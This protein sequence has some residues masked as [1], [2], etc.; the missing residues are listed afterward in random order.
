MK[1]PTVSELATELRAINRNVECDPGG[2]WAN[3]TGCDVRLQVYPDGQWAVRW[4]SSDYDQDHRGYWGASVIPGVV[5][6]IEID[7]DAEE[8]AQDLLEQAE[9]QRQWERIDAG[10]ED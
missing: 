2:D 5:R 1:F 7:F 6:G 10:E 8:I 3:S 9:E 4:G